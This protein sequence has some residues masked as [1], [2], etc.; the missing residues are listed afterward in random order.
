MCVRSTKRSPSTFNVFPKRPQGVQNAPK[1]YTFFFQLAGHSQVHSLSEVRPEKELEH[2]KI[3]VSAWEN[4]VMGFDPAQP[5]YAIFHGL[6]TF[7]LFEGKKIHRTAHCSTT[8]YT[9]TAKKKKKTTKL[10]LFK[11]KLLCEIAFLTAFFYTTSEL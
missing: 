1:E 11:S 9:S 8:S 6:V 4:L 2:K 3:T 7:A 10:S 5:I